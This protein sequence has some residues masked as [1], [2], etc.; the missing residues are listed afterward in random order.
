MDKY[1][2]DKYEKNEAPFE[3]GM[4][5]VVIIYRLGGTNNPRKSNKIKK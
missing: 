4:F 5:T 3:G 1:I 2:F